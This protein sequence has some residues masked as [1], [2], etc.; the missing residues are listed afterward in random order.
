[1]LF[2]KSLDKKKKKSRACSLVKKEKGKVAQLAGQ[3]ARD[4]GRSIELADAAIASTAIIN[5][6]ELATLNKKHFLG[7]KDLRFLEL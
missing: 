5:D 1:L 7:I 6:F 4:L 2:P 3:I